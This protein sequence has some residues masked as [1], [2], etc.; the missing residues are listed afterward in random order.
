MRLRCPVCGAPLRRRENAFACA[1]GHSFDLAR[2]GYVNLLTVSQKHSKSPGDTK[3][4]VNA[5]RAFLSAGYYRPIA[6]TLCR[7]AAPLLP[8]RIVD[9]GCGEGYYLD[10]LRQALPQAELLGL[11]ISKEAVR[12]AAG[13]YK[14]PT[15]LTATAAA[16][17]LFDQSADLILSLFALTAAAE[18]HR[19]L[20]P[21]GHFLQVLAGEAHLLGLKSIIYPQLFHKEKISHPVLPGFSLA[22]SETLEFSFTLETQRDV[23]NLLY[24]TPHVYRISREGLARLRATP[25]LTDRAQV[26]FNLYRKE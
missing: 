25:R 13:Q 16:M 9:A 17:P 19:V 22:K 1:A 2:Q 8:S 4:Q 21:G 23:E 24:M 3:E 18:F 12:C 6:E 5:R 10:A 14:V 20:T 11:D 26:I 15:F 7:L